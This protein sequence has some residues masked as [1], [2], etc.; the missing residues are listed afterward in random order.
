MFI[1]LV[2][3]LNTQR[4]VK[5]EML[6]GSASEASLQYGRK[7]WHR[8]PGVLTHWGQ[9]PQHTS[10]QCPASPNKPHHPPFPLV[11]PVPSRSIPSDG[12]NRSSGLSPQDLPHLRDTRTDNPRM[13]FANLHSLNPIKLTVGFAG[14]LSEASEG[15]LHCQHLASGFPGRSAKESV[16]AALS[17]L[18]LM[19]TAARQEL[20]EP[21][22]GPWLH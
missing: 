16:S 14:S 17:L 2:P 3:W 5:G 20:W 6:C 4:T 19:H 11:L 13:H 1:R 18:M 8:N 15:S 22:L 10:H 21:R 7:V 12:L 9:A